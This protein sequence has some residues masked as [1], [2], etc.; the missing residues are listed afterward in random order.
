MAS[1]SCL[2]A[3]SSSSTRQAMVVSCHNPMKILFVSAEAYPFAKAGGLGDVSYAL[4]KAL[5]EQGVDVRVIIPKYKFSNK[6]RKG[7]KKKASYKTYIGWRTVD[8]SLWYCERDNIPFY[9]IEN[10]YYFG[11]KDI[12]GYEDDNERF[13][14][15]C[16]AILEGIKYMGDFVPDI[17]HCNDW[18]SALA[19]LFLEAFYRKD[20]RY[21]GIK[22]VFT[23][24]N[25]IYQGAFGKDALWMLGVDE[26]KYYNEHCLK[27]YDGVNF[28]KGAL[29]LADKITTVSETYAKELL[30][31]WFS[32]GLEKVL[33]KRKK[34]FS[35]ILNGIDYDVFNPETDEDIFFKYDKDHISL[36]L[37]NK[38]EMQRALGFEKDASI[39][40]IGMV[41]RLTEQK[42][43]D[44]IQYA[45]EEM[46]SMNM[47]LVVTGTGS[48]DYENMFKYYSSKYPNKVAAH[49]NFNPKL[50]KKIY[51]AS[52]MFLMPS[53]LEP[54]GL[55]QMIAMR[56]GAVPIVRSTGGL[57]D[58]VKE[59][60]EYTKEGNGFTFKNFDAIDMIHSIKRAL[61]IY[62]NK[63]LWEILIQNSM[64]AQNRWD[65]SAYKYIKLYKSLSK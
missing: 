60:N 62:S 2:L 31:P 37:Q 14:Y 63:T 26:E 19:V 29:S 53:K 15:F 34:D 52:D 65:N 58:T 8:C 51:A 17:I 50:S 48:I 25:M 40:M 21:Q 16:K 54:C 44:L 46:L 30:N 22:T 49:I 35:G 12:Y 33:N 39:P 59:F 45:V 57:K 56:Y 42:G 36:K 10:P 64:N 20:K 61:N 4:P 47:Q 18:H 38:L 7:F 11:R 13:I 24:H 3:S 55:A 23:I 28:M 5:R 6:M 41:T 27:Y 32:Y 9:F 1:W 43:I